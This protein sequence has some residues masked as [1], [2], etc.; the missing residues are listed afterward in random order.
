MR[1]LLTSL[2]CVFTLSLTAQEPLTY[3]Y[4]PDANGDTLIG[5]SDVLE[6]ISIYGS[7]FLP[8]D[9]MVGDTT[10]SHWIQ[11]INQTLM[12]QQT[13]IDSLQAYE[14]NLMYDMQPEIDEF[15]LNYIYADGPPHF[16]VITIPS[17]YENVIMIGSSSSYCNTNNCERA[18]VEISGGEL[19][20]A[21]TI[22]WEANNL[23]L[24]N[25]GIYQSGAINTGHVRVIKMI[26]GWIGE[27]R[28]TN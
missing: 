17:G 2:L 11:I 27:Y 7:E 25:F 8:S 22:I 28:M 20:D 12:N 9:I 6:T 10:L 4:N 3:P 23:R 21:T 18:N 24:M 1:C 13:V 16:P 14:N 5:V 15:W 26:N 19:Y